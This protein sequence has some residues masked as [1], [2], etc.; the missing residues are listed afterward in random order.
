MKESFV[1]IAAVVFALVLA[2][3]FACDVRW[4]FNRP[5]V[6]ETHYWTN[7]GTEIGQFTWRPE[8]VD[9]VQPPVAWVPTSLVGFSSGFQATLSQPHV[10][11]TRAT[12]R[13]HGTLVGPNFEF[14]QNSGQFNYVGFR[15]GVPWSWDSY[16][17]TRDGTVRALC[18]DLTEWVV[19]DNFLRTLTDPGRPEAPNPF[20]DN[21]PL[22]LPVVG[23]HFF[24]FVNLYCIDCT[25][26]NVG[27]LDRSNGLFNNFV[28]GR[29]V[30]NLSL[31]NATE[32]AT[33]SEEK[34]KAEVAEVKIEAAGAN[35]VPANQATDGPH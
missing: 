27:L 31:G 16:I 24:V 30:L 33:D 4:S 8:P 2:H 11:L 26:R 17:L 25:F 7:G 9:G 5:G 14:Y 20:V 28:A 32:A 29:G 19:D 15:L 22:N 12:P 1:A 21:D 10:T 13:S 18:D 6:V 3:S 35:E 34:P 23:N